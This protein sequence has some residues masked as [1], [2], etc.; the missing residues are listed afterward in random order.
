MKPLHK[1]ILPA[2]AVNPK[3]FSHRLW[4]TKGNPK[5]EV[6]PMKEQNIKQYR[7]DIELLFGQWKAKERHQN[8]VF[9][10]DGIVDPEYWFG[11]H[12]S[13]KPR[14]LFLLKEA[15]HSS[16]DEAQRRSSG[17]MIY[18]LAHELKE[19][20]PWGNIWTRVA[21]WA[22]GISDIWTDFGKPSASVVMPEYEPLDKGQ[23]NDWL[24]R[25]AVV[26][27]KKSAGVPETD[28]EELAGYSQY[29][30]EELYREIYEIIKPDII[31]CGNTFSELRAINPR[32]RDVPASEAWRYDDEGI[33]TVDYYHPS[34]RWSAR[35]SFYGLVATCFHA[36]KKS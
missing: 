9:N 28:M 3:D 20:G 4:Y 1:A 17:E 7:E 8:Q 25:I 14:I 26:N 31:I 29:D 12:D 35:L 34:I 24:R 18:D 30:S 13:G 32:L 27:V 16:D 2:A 33:L 15:Y 19:Y 5:K 10:Y 23:C 6:M 22:K 11:L 21:E 36:A